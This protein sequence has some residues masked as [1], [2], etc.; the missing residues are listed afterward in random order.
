MGRHMLPMV[1]LISLNLFFLILGNANLWFIF[2]NLR[3]LE[4]VSVC[5]TNLLILFLLSYLNGLRLLLVPSPLSV[6]LV[7][8]LNILCRLINMKKNG[9]RSGIVIAIRMESRNR[10]SS[11]GPDF[12][13]HVFKGYNVQ[14]ALPRS[15]AVCSVC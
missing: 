8:L 3:D 1:I 12:G 5:L 2:V 10:W 9:L 14:R 7:R 15:D 4:N 6:E 13:R 11:N